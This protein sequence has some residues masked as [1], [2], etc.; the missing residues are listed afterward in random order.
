MRLSDTSIRLYRKR[1]G[2]VSVR[3]RSFLMIDCKGSEGFKLSTYLNTIEGSVRFDSGQLVEFDQISYTET[4][5]FR[6][7]HM[8]HDF[9]A[10]GSAEMESLSNGAA[11]LHIEYRLF[12][13]P[14]QGSPDVI[15]LVVPVLARGIRSHQWKSYLSNLHPH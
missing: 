8:I 1:N 6:L 7:G 11:T 15:E 12:S 14:G 13:G 5:L 2:S 9:W 3:L 4:C 10:S